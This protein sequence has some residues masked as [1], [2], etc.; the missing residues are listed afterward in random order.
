MAKLGIINDI[1]SIGD[2]WVLRIPTDS[3]YSSSLMGESV[4]MAAAGANGVMTPKLVLFDDDLD[5]VEVPLMVTERV[6]GQTLGTFEKSPTWGLAGHRWA[7]LLDELGRQ[8]T[9]IH[10]IAIVDDPKGWL[11][12]WW[13]DDPLEELG[14]CVERG[15]LSVDDADWCT[16][17]VARLQ[18][19]FSYEPTGPSGHSVFVH[20]DVHPW[21]LLASD[22]GL[23]AVLDWGCACFGDP[24]VDFSG[25]PL[26]A[27]PPLLDSYKEH[28]GVSGPDFEG[29]I[30]WMWLGVAVREPLFLDPKSFARHWWRLPEDGVRELRYRLPMMPEAWRRWSVD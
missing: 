9:L 19:A 17:F 7:R 25:M 20:H 16:R 23:A 29:R 12:P 24:A 3:N 15:V 11:S 18:S 21:N 13:V 28:G 22:E 6:Q 26:W 5:I 4:A 8:L 10:Q 14:D 2:K 1:W 30:L 27:L